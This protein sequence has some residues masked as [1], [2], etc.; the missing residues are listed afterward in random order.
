MADAVIDIEALGAPKAM[1][2]KI[3]PDADQGANAPN[4]R[5]PAAPSR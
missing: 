1:Q 5:S 3:A 2:A 4:E